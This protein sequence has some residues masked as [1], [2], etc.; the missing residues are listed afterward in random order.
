MR[1]DKIYDKFKE[2]V[3][4]P[5][6]RKNIHI[7]DQCIINTVLKGKIGIL[8]PKYGSINIYEEGKNKSLTH[9]KSPFAYTPQEREEAFKNGFIVHFKMW[10]ENTTP[11]YMDLWWNKYA[12]LTPVYE[13]L[14][15]K[16]YK[17]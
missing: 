8:K 10:K 9:Q 4:N 5:A 3:L 2:Y 12:N 16:L 1:N 13:I 14:K 17:L 6:S 15:Q 7:K 11:S